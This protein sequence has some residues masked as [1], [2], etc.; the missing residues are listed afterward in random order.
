MTY[1]LERQEQS[2]PKELDTSDKIAIGIGIPSAI[3]A[4][5]TLVITGWALYYAKREFIDKR[6]EKRQAV[7]NRRKKELRNRM[8]QSKKVDQQHLGEPQDDDV[9]QQDS[10][11]KDERAGVSEG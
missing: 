1:I 2:V 6:K 9:G 11:E 10:D 5:I 3:V 8:K 7:V 4:I